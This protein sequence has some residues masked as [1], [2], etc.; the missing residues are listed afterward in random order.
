MQFHPDFQKLVSR[1]QN[2]EVGTPERKV[3]MQIFE[4]KIAIFPGTAF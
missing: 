3:N 1:L 2:Q 4:Q